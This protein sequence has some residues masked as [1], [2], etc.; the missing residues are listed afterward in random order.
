[1]KRRRFFQ[2]A[3]AAGLA[4]GLGAPSPRAR[5]AQPSPSAAGRGARKPRIMFYHDGRHPLI[6]M[7]E[8]PMQ[9]EEYDSAVDELLGTPV[10]ALM[11]TMG[12]GR[13]VLHDTR[14]GELW[15]HHVSK[16]PHLIFRRAHQNAKGLIQAGQDPLRIVCDRARGRGMLVYPVLLVQQGTGKRGEDTRAS[17]FRFKHR[18]LEIGAGVGVD[19]AFPGFHGL[20]FKH[21][22][23][24]RERFALIEET[25]ERYPVD[26]FELQLNYMPYYFR[27]DEVEPG[28]RIMT[29]W[30]RRVFQAVKRS[31]EG[32]ELVLRVPASLERCESVGLDI[33]EWLRQGMVDVL[34]PQ[35]PGHFDQM[36]DLGPMVSAARGSG[37]RIH[38]YLPSTVDSDR[39]MESTLPVTR[40]AASNLWDQGVDG[41]YVAQWFNN[42]PYRSSF[43]ERLRELPH[44]EVMAP[45]D[46]VYFLQTTTGRYPN[47]AGRQLPADLEVN[48]PVSLEF[49][50]SDDLPRWA[51]TG[52][53]HQVLLRVRLSNTTE[54]DRIAFRLN[55]KPLPDSRLRKINEMF[56]LKV[57]RHFQFGYWFVYKLDPGHWPDRGLNRLEVELK[58]RDPEVTPQIA[59]S[60]LELE[61]KYLLGK[62]MRRDSE[63]DLGAQ[64]S[65]ND[66]HG[67]A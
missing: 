44:P 45:R 11:F 7:Y 20:D 25:L 4:G 67:K 37:C 3:T 30:I 10:E 16:W 1:M 27:P 51:K 12:D 33:R 55:G 8:P 53:V 39:L 43:Y 46:K 29:E 40:A 47:R 26:G 49:K 2:T 50:I 42:W 19:P 13:T 24:R 38:G 36:L 21:E 65:R 31:G 6:Y 28:R 34:I 22:A 64:E 32:R 59:V 62:H 58:Q 18:H 56:K 23:V 66:R 48:R 35:G 57:P 5:Q 63:T 41:L 61:I 14:V 60:N 54:L 9:K 15:G 17:E 52:R